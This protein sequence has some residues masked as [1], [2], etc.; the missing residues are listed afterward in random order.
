MRTHSRE[1][2][3]SSGPGVPW[4][5]LVCIALAI[6]CAW[7][8]LQLSTQQSLFVSTRG[9]VLSQLRLPDSLAFFQDHTF[10][11]GMSAALALIIWA[12]FRRPRSR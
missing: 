6:F 4:F 7:A 12:M 9:T 2:H 11:V 5:G 3:R 10:V 8:V 1:P